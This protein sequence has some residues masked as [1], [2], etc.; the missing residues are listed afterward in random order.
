MVQVFIRPLQLKVPF[1]FVMGSLNDTYKIKS[2]SF[3]V[4]PGGVF[5]C[6]SH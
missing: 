6:C 1:S 5:C 2:E 4:V 3:W